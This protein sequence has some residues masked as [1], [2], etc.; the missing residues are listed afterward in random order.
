MCDVA[1]MDQRV[2]IEKILRPLSLWSATPWLARA[3]PDADEGSRPR[4]P[5]DD[6]DPMPD[7]E[8]VLTD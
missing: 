5:L 1:V 2:V 3:P 6:V 8:N 4:E 7:Y